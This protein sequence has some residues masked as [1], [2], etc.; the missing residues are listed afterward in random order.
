MSG[1]RIVFIGSEEI[2]WR[3]LETLIS[4]GTSI[5]GA[6][7]LSESLAREAVAFRSFAPFAD[8]SVPLHFV[9]DINAK[10]VAACIRAMR[11]DLVYQIGWSQLLKEEILEIP[12]DGCVGMHCSLL[13]KHRGRAPIPWSII[14]GLR[15]SGMSLFH[16]TP[17]ADAGALIGQE[18]FV[19]L[20]NDSATEVYEK[21]VNAAV[22]LVRTFHPQLEAGTAPRM[23]QDQ[24]P[25]DR[26]PRRT[27]DDGLIDWDRSARHLYDW[28]RALTHP[29]PGAFTFWRARKL[30]IWRARPGDVDTA[31]AAGT[32][33]AVDSERGVLVGTGEG[34]L[35]LT[36][37]QWHG[38]EERQAADFAGQ[39]GFSVGECLA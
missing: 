37:V 31:P 17:T 8:R 38:E 23:S 13:P 12:R 9:E 7:T 24:R 10:P 39:H 28:V 6:F 25:S 20:P 35:W 16:L 14:F 36:S 27:P 30:T 4:V 21:A 5:A 18:P 22:R 34:A 11:P 19:I 3:C 32:V 29:F 33:L 26:W 1:K 15:R 2:G